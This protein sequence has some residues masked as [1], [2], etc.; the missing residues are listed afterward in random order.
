[1]EHL[2]P[3]LLWPIRLT[4]SVVHFCWFLCF[5][6]W[7]FPK[8]GYL[9]GVLLMRESFIRY[10]AL[11]YY[12]IPHYTILYYIILYCFIYYIWGP[13]FSEIPTYEPC[14]SDEQTAPGMSEVALVLSRE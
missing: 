9:I 11:L 14:I 7:G 1:M 6:T 13:L 12:S 2:W 4:Q 10:S 3:A 5:F 8:V